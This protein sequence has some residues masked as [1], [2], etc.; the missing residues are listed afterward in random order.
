MSGGGDPNVGFAYLPKW[1]QRWGY[2]TV[3]WVAL[4]V[5]ERGPEAGAHGR[6][7]GHPESQSD[8]RELGGRRGGTKAWAAG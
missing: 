1:W 8:V 3:N 2:W 6:L 5:K 4:R 7:T